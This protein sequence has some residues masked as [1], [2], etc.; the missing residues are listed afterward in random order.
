MELAINGA[1]WAGMEATSSGILCQISHPLWTDGD[2]EFGIGTGN[3]VADVPPPAAH[4]Y[5]QH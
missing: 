4:E 5:A 2:R 3:W 1:A